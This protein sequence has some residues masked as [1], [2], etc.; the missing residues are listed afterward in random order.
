[1]PKPKISTKYAKNVTGYITSRKQMLD[2][3]AAFVRDFESKQYGP[4]QAIHAGKDGKCVILTRY[5][6]VRVATLK[7][8]KAILESK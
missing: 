1:M 6:R 7:Q 2:Y 4:K 3:G 8:M 5:V